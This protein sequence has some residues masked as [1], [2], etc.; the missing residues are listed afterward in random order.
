MNPHSDPTVPAGSYAYPPAI[1]SDPAQRPVPAVT[2]AGGKTTPGPYRPASPMTFRTLPEVN[3]AELRA[4]S[5]SEIIVPFSITDTTETATLPAALA[6]T[7]NLTAGEQEALNGMAESFV[8]EVS[9]IPATPSDH[10]YQE[11]WR[12][13][14]E[15]NDAQ[16]KA[17][18]GGH[19]WL[20]Q[21][22]ESRHQA[23]SQAT[24]P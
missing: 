12:Q 21:H 23:H 14:Q 2:L 4:E 6:T 10:A 24:S 16:F 9:R 18:F 19:A 20:R 15:G 8:N 3:A 17:R 7:E 22:T 11:L 13:S 5:P 1:T